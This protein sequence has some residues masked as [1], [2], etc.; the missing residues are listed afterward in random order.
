M[1][2]TYSS[3]LYMRITSV[4]IAALL[5]S[6]ALVL[7][8]ASASQQALGQQQLSDQQEAQ[9]SIQK[10]ETMVNDLKVLRP[11][12]NE[13]TNDLAVNPVSLLNYLNS[14][15]PTEGIRTLL[16]LETLRLLMN[17]RASYLIDESLTGQAD[18]AGQITP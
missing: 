14:L 4:I 2:I 17:L 5:S 13:I 15:E 18:P 12:L 11:E 9:S 7:S 6:S 16:A 10:I 8:S 1:D 3:T